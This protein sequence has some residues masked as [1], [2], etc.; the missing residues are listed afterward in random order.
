LEAFIDEAMFAA[1]RIA[2]VGKTLG[3]PEL[4]EAA[5]RT[6]GAIAAYK[7]EFGSAELRSVFY[8]RIC[9]LAGIIE[10]ICAD[11]DECLG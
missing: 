6:E 9:Q 8:S 3:F 10:A 4:G 1:H 11:H 5:R 7:K 2:G